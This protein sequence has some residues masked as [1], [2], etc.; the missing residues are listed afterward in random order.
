[1]AKPRVPHPGRILLH[2]WLDPCGISQNELAR[3]MRL[4]PRRVNQI[5]LGNRAIT[6]DTALR[7]GQMFGLDPRYWMRLQMEY[8]LDQALLPPDQRAKKLPAPKRGRAARRYDAIRFLMD[9][10]IRIWD[11]PASR[12]GPKDL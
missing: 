11:L 8:E 2:E 4:S 9:D 7:L 10:G 5:V 3:H 6:A 1:M 12:E